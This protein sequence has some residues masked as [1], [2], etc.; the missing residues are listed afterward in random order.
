MSKE[1]FDI[2]KYLLEKLIIILSS[3][4]PYMPIIYVAVGAIIPALSSLLS[5]HYKYKK[6][7]EEKIRELLGDAIY[8]SELLIS[9]YKE[10]VMHKVHKNYWFQSCEHYKLKDSKYA[11]IYYSKHFESSKNA[12]SVEYR[13]G[14]LLAAYIKTIKKYELYNGKIEKVDLIIKEINE[15]KPRKPKE[16]EDVFAPDLQTA[17]NDE[18]DALNKEY[19]KYGD[20][21]Y[22]INKILEGGISQYSKK[23]QIV[24]WLTGFFCGTGA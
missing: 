6:R 13:I 10:L 5:Y 12:F 4:N 14:K 2:L 7:K 3:Q 9:S 11:E 16:F 19:A 24:K 15:Y 20:Y 23:K 8:Q 17:S 21:F 1:E 22:Q 18:E